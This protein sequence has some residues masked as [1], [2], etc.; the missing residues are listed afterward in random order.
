MRRHILYPG[1]DVFCKE[2]QVRSPS[3]ITSC[4]YCGNSI[5][6]HELHIAMARRGQAPIYICRRCFGANVIVRGQSANSMTLG[7]WDNGAPAL[8]LEMSLR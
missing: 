7:R 5:H 2:H 1:R 3:V 4:V 6:V 8:Q